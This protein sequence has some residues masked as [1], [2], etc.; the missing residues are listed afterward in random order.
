MQ[1]NLETVGGL[2]YTPDEIEFGK[3]LQ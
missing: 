3:K 2:S 1:K